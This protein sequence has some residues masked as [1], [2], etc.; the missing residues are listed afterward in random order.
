LH[1]D[2]AKRRPVIVVDTQILNSEAGTIVVV[3]CTSTVFPDNQDAIELPNRQRMPQTH[4]RLIKRTW[5]IPH[6]YAFVKTDR[7]VGRLSYI[8]GPLLRRVVAEFAIHFA[9]DKAQRDA[10]NKNKPSP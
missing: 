4:S 8:S 3:A 6:G 1:G 10:A 9:R 2:V 5:A 7:F